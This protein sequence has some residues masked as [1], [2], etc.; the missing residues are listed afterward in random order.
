MDSE[1]RT[2]FLNLN[3]AVDQ[4]DWPMTER[5]L[6][7]LGALILAVMEPSKPATKGDGGGFIMA[8]DPNPSYV[9]PDPKR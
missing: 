2:I 4:R 6:D 5:A 8:L 3:K 9:P 1:L 7:R